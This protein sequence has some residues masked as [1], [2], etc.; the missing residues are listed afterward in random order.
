MYRLNRIG[1]W[2]LVNLNIAAQTDAN[3][4]FGTMETAMATYSACSLNTAS[5][6]TIARE[7]RFY[8]DL[9]GVSLS[10]VNQVGLGVQ[11]TN[12]NEANHRHMYAVSGFIQFDQGAHLNVEFCIGRLT[13]APSATVAVNI[14]NA[15]TI[16]LS[17]CD[18][19]QNIFHAGINTTV[20]SD[21]SVG[22]QP[23]THW[24]LCAFWRIVNI[25]GGA[26]TLKGLNLGVQLHQYREDL[27]TWDPPRV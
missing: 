27:S 25:S 10:N 13:A 7:Q 8:T 22:S 6:S 14:P 9:T 21:E 19:T 5:G 15:N 16:P 17:Y 11:I 23:A 3:T 2:P 1:P 4:A 24:D 20:V 26:V 18:N 12:T